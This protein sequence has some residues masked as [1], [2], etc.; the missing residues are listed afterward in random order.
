LGSTNFGRRSLNRDIEAQVLMITDNKKL[1][2][3]MANVCIK[4]DFIKI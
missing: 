4:K 1:Q 3:D 2:K